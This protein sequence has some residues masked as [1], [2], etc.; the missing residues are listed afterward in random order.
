[1]SEK[2]CNK[3]LYLIV[4]AD[5]SAWG[6]YIRR[7]QMSA[8]KRTTVSKGARRQTRAIWTSV[9]AI[10]PKQTAIDATAR[11]LSQKKLYTF[12]HSGLD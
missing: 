8:A 10:D 11:V 2:L 9:L 3:P 12:C 7:S 1:M 4:T 5:R 6:N